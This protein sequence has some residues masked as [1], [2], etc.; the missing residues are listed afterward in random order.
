MDGLPFSTTDLVVLGGIGLVGLMGAFWGFV[1][2]VTGIGAWVGALAITVL[3]YPRAQEFAR[4]QI[5]QELFADV[6]AGVALFAGSLIIFMALSAALSHVVK[7][8]ALGSINRA[9]G[10]VS[11]VGVGYV[12]CCALLLGA[13]LLFEEGGIAP[14]IRDSRSYELVRAGG[15]A[16]LE[17]LPEDT[18]S[19]I[20]SKLEQG[21]QS[22]DALETLQ[23]LQP[24]VE[25]DAPQGETGYSNQDNAGL[26]NVI[27]QSN[28]Q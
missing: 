17:V 19:Y 21:R 6:G 12:I 16:I 10:F 24:P 20:L 22:I 3:G 5:E 15:V 27:E 2:L 14:E 7:E 26:L 23:Q 1:G 13:V 8:S 9:L 25:G 28:E 11:G 4:T 18:G